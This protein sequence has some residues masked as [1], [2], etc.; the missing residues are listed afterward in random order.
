MATGNEAVTKVVL[1]EYLGTLASALVPGSLDPEVT[2]EFLQNYFGDTYD[3]LFSDQQTAIVGVA[4]FLREYY[5]PSLVSARGGEILLSGGY[6]KLFK[7]TSDEPITP[8]ASDAQANGDVAA[9]VNSSSGYRFAIINERFTIT[10]KDFFQVLAPRDVKDI[11]QAAN[12]LDRIK[13]AGLFDLLFYKPKIQQYA[14]KRY[15]SKEALEKSAIEFADEAGEDL[16]WL[17]ALA[18]VYNTVV[19]D[20]ITTWLMYQYF[21]RLAEFIF[22]AL[23]STADYSNNG[24]GGSENDPL[25]DPIEM[26]KR[27]FKAFGTDEKGDAVFKPAW[28]LINTA[29]R[30]QRALEE[31]PFRANIPPRPPDI[32]HLR[33]GAAN[34]YV[35]PVSINVNSMFKTGSLTGGAIRQKN[36][37]KFNAGYKETTV[38][39]RLFFPNYEEIW[40]ISIKDAANIDLSKDNFSIDFSVDNEDK[41]DKFLSS[42]R[43]LIAAFKYS[44]II[45]IKNQYLNAV[46]GITGVALANMSISTIPNFPF[47]LVVDLELNSFNHKPF[48]PMIKDFNQAVHWGKYRHYM[49]RAAISLDSYIN[50]D[51]LT[52]SKVIE[53]QNEATAALGAPNVTGSIET[54][55]SSASVL[56]T[57]TSEDFSSV[58]NSI[59]EP[60]DS[61]LDT[62]IIRDWENG[63]N[64]SF[65]M[66]ER[67]QSKIFTPDVSTF[68]SQQEKVLNDTGRN[69]WGALLYKF[70]IDINESAGYG[71]T[72][73]QVVV[74]SQGYT[75]SMSLKRKLRT[76]IDLMLAG[77]NEEG[78]NNKVYNYLA[79]S[80]ILNNP[81]VYTVPNAVEYILKQSDV[82]PS[83]DLRI[84]PVGVHA[85]GE[86]DTGQQKENG[87]FIRN[88]LEQLSFGSEGLLE[89]LVSEMVE[90]R[91]KSEKIRDTE[92]NRANIRAEVKEEIAKAFNNTLYERFFM[93]GPIKDYIESQ[94]AKENAYSFREWEVPMVQ[95]DLDPE[96]VIVDG[97]SVNLGNSLV[98]LQLQMQEEPTYQH[99]GGKDSY[100]S[101][102]MTVF[103]E[104]ELIKLRNI[105]EHINGLARLEHAAGVIGFLGIKN[106][107]TSLCG[108]KYVL[109]LKY[110][111]D[112]IPSFPHVYKVQLTLVDFD[113]FQQKREKLSSDQ[114]QKF[115]DEFGTKRNPFLRIKQLWGAFNAYPDLPLELYD[116]NGDVAGCLDPDYYFRSFEMMDRDVVVNQSIQESSQVVV[117]YE[118]ENLTE[119][120]EKTRVREDNAYVE[121][122]V[123]YLKKDDLDGLKVYFQNNKITPTRGYKIINMAI[124]KYSASFNKTLLLDYVDTLDIDDKVYLFTDTKFSVPMGEY[125]V[126]EI[127]SGSAAEMK[128]KLDAV[129]NQTASL[130][131][132][133]VS[134][135]PD[136]LTGSSEGSDSEYSYLHGLVYAIPAADDGWSDQIPA[137][138]QTAGGYNFGYLSRTNGRFYLQNN[139]FTVKKINKEAR[140]RAKAQ[141]ID[142]NATEEQKKQA[143]DLLDMLPERSE[144]ETTDAVTM[145]KVA[146]SQTPDKALKNAHMSEIGTKAFSEYQYAYSGGGAE[147]ESISAGSGDQFSVTKH[148]E[149]MLVDTS[150]RDISGRMVRA[151]PTYMLWLIDEGGFF[152]GTKLFDNFYGLQSIIDFSIVQSEDLLGD[153]LVFR[154]SNMYSKLTRP[155]AS[156]ILRSGSEAYSEYNGENENQ[157]ADNM[158][159]A[160]DRIVD[161]LLNRQ[162]NIRRH[163]ESKYVVDIENIRLKPGVRVH[164]RGGYGSNPNSLQT[165]FNGMITNVEQGEIMTITCQSDAIELSPIINSANKKG[166]SG[167]IDGGMN[168]GMF[169]SEPRDL[170]VKLLSMGTSRFRE[171]LAHSTRGTI[172]SE[173]KFGIRHFGHILYE[174]LNELEAQKNNAIKTAFKNAIEAASDDK[175]NA[176]SLLKAAWK[177]T[178]GSYNGVDIGAGIVSASVGGLVG[179]PMGA[180]AAGTAGFAMRSPIVGH[181]RTLLAN[182]STQRDYEIFKRNIYPG[183]GL[184]VSQFL[185]G[186]LDAGWS[187]AATISGDMHD[188]LQ[189]DRQA[190][191]RRLGDAQWATAVEKESQIAE[192]TARRTSGPLQDSS[193]IIGSAKLISGLGSIAGVGLLAAGMPVVGSAML[194]AGLLGVTNG[195]AAASI[196]ETMGLLSSMDDDMPGFDEVSFRAQT[197]MRSVWDMFQLC[198]RLLPNYIVAVRPFEDRSTVFYGKPH[199]LYTSGV[200]PI[201]TGFLNPDSALKAGVKD[202]GPTLQR[203]DQE[204]VDLLNK[205]NQASSP[206][207]DATAF[208]R[209]FEPFE[210]LKQ[211]TGKIYEGS[212]EFAP[213]GYIR[214]KYTNKLINFYDPRRLFWKEN[215]K[216]VA[217]LPANKGLVNVGFHLPFGEDQ[218]KTELSISEF[219]ANHK[220]IPQLPYRYQFPYFTDRKT[221][222]FDGRHNGYI[223]N[224]SANDLLGIAQGG[225]TDEQRSNKFAGAQEYKTLF[226]A[227]LKALTTSGAGLV[228]LGENLAVQENGFYKLDAFQFSKNLLETISSEAALAMSGKAFMDGGDASSGSFNIIRMPF[229]P[230]SD[231]KISKEEATEPENYKSSSSILLGKYK[232]MAGDTETQSY[233]DFE[234]SADVYSGKAIHKYIRE[235]NIYKEWGMPKTAEDEQFYIAMRW[236]YNPSWFQADDALTK[237]FI[238]VYSNTNLGIN[239]GIDAEDYSS[240]MFGEAQDYKNR[241]VLVYSPTTN[242]AVCCRPAYFLW[243][244]QKD[245]TLREYKMDLGE[246]SY[247]DIENPMI[248]AVVSPDAAYYL[249]ILT[250]TQTINP[251]VGAG[252]DLFGSFGADLLLNIGAGGAGSSAAN[253]PIP[254][255]RQIVEYLESFRE[256]SG[257]SNKFWEK[258]NAGQYFGSYIVPTT[259]S[260]YFTFVEDDFPLGVIPAPIIQPQEYSYSSDSDPGTK[261]KSDKSYIIGFGRSKGKDNQ[262]VTSAVFEGQNDIEFD[263]FKNTS[264]GGTVYREYGYLK[265]ILEDQSLLQNNESITDNLFTPANEAVIDFET[266]KDAAIKSAIGGNVSADFENKFKGYFQ[267]IL[268]GSYDDISPDS[269]YD[270]LA[271]E[272]N[273]FK[274]GDDKDDKGRN[275][276]KDIYD[277]VNDFMIADQARRNYD[278]DFDPA[279]AVIAGNGRT[280]GQAREIWDFFRI[281]FHEDKTV[282][283]IFF[284]AYGI[285]PDD[286]EE[287]PGP[288]LALLTSDSSSDDEI[289]ERYTG[290]YKVG[291]KGFLRNRDA[292]DE[293]EQLLGEEY[294]QRGVQS[295]DSTGG[296]VENLD[297]AKIKE[298]VNYSSEKF[299]DLSETNSE[300]K[301]VRS[302]L[303]QDLD[304]LLMGKYGH[305][306]GLLRFIITPTGNTTGI[307]DE[308][309][310]SEDPTTR[311]IAAFRASLGIDENNASDILEKINSPRKLYLMIVGWF[312]QV[313]WADPYYRAWVVLKPNRRLK[314][315]SSNPLIGGLGDGDLKKSD[316]KWDFSPIFKAWQ[317]F[318]DPNSDYA[319]KPAKFK[320][321]LVANAAEGDSATHWMTAAF[322]DTKDFWD[323][324]IGVYFTAVSDGLSGLLNM[325]KLSMAQMGYGLAEVDNL[326]KQANVL[327]KLLNDSIY[328]SLG[329]PGSLLRAV[330][331]PFTRE[332][333]EPVVEVREPFQR[334]HYLSSFSHILANNIQENINDV[335]TVVTAVSDGKYPVTVAL[336]KGAPPE[337]QTEKTVET[338]LYFD[339]IRGSGFFGVLHPLF[340]P[341]ETIRGVSK[342]SQGAPDE[343]TARRV[344]LAHLKESIKDIYSGELT[345]IGSPDIRPHDLVYLADVYERMYGIFEVEQVVHHFTPDLGFITSITP[346]ALVTVND[347]ARWF[348]TSWLNSWMS[349]QTIRNDTRMYISSANNGRTGIVTGGQV[350]MDS[351]NEALSAQMMGGIQYTHGHSA[352]MKDV[353][354]NF[355]ANALPDTRDKLL[356]QAKNAAGLNGNVS[357]TGALVSTGLATVLGA[358]VGVA[359]T[360]LTGG[361]AA[362]LLAFAG[363]AVA[364][365]AIFGDM[366]W[367][368][369]KYIRDNTLDQHGCYVQYLSKNGQ[370]MDAGLSYNQ[371][372][373][374]GKYHSKAMLPGILGVNS[375]K[376]VRTPEGYSYIRTDDL[377]KNLGWKEK[378]ISDLIRH[379]SYENALVNAQVIKY[380]GVGPEKA[381]LNQFFKVLCYVTRYIDGDTFEVQDILRP[382]SSPF[383]VRFDGINA[384]ELNKI[385]GYITEVGPNYESDYSGSWTDTTSPGGKAAGYVR[386]ALRGKLFVLRVAPSKNLSSELIPINDFDAGAKRNEPNN[387]L[388]DFSSS[389]N[390]FGTNI[391]GTNDRVMGTIFYRTTSNDLDGIVAFVRRTFVEKF[392][393][394][395][396]CKEAIK[397]SIYSDTLANSGT[398]VVHQQFDL[399]YRYL[400]DSSTTNHYSKVSSTEGLTELTQAQINAF[401]ALVEIK[402]LELLYAKASDWPLILWDEF[403]E[404]G[405]PATL[406]WELVVNNLASVYTK[407]LLYNEDSVTLDSNNAYG[408]MVG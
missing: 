30:M 312:R 182:L 289:F 213:V 16:D 401:N 121:T 34:F 206:M 258:D 390:G 70:G 69:F 369:W 51:F 325:F 85:A 8:I 112:T 331:N 167:K 396:L 173:N 223:F 101:M 93:S 405:S 337:R 317:A 27:L 63:N 397:N 283:S 291:S 342:L 377:L 59:N 156:E 58:N 147:P 192:N 137:M 311:S 194:G 208:L 324:N 305:L 329:N 132:E 255:S 298:A 185:G 203:G 10:P 18:K 136:N 394:V 274:D 300:G 201:S 43:G 97:V 168:T 118:S 102:S 114:Q 135:D 81:I 386:D 215:N 392:S 165:L 366:A 110:S 380:S 372:M 103:G 211:Q 183:N 146:D 23:A 166:D 259:R 45:P 100:V 260:C 383:V 163:F 221:G 130:N 74:T 152:A 92:Q 19:K 345:V 86:E 265:E 328:Y 199:W 170:M 171:A 98:K 293:F 120:E 362:P 402:K 139:D 219:D 217:R 68:R 9:A 257:V 126:G 384:G 236:P 280:L 361:A 403:Y 278:E 144:T 33:L 177:N 230:G 352:L 109:P 388:K 57:N 72:L 308:E 91:I 338:G 378:E 216:I 261:W 314:H 315:H 161:V 55:S 141:A 408:R 47:C 292:L 158:G 307:S 61:T 351:L 52:N 54:Q 309:L 207:A 247:I 214:D 29:V 326:N 320:A 187:T 174:P 172:F 197:Y 290:T 210:A 179:G 31:F 269:L 370:P 356:E 244:N 123:E 193:N 284:D 243:G 279:V 341:F 17:A 340:H 209:S 35:P 41:I 48:L 44:P 49:G 233:A 178:A 189:S 198:A 39:I 191:L 205:V 117:S 84:F 319:K 271:S 60:L 5:A 14:R 128:S 13:E 6:N 89:K 251:A 330:D 24:Y 99:V 56:S 253:L 399:L 316:G 157:Q 169:L 254:K 273:T 90:E 381:G 235:N 164:L 155:E 176:A 267:S 256:G 3:L 240:F 248:D 119:D 228:S 268:D 32:F 252:I 181:M 125:K 129:F 115:V 106:I 148:W 175:S 407:G 94:Q 359:A 288:I 154:V 371:G 301:I 153:T 344:A 270:L 239:G 272:V 151:F 113:I 379:I 387:Y 231:D 357:F 353:M 237:K 276:F 21:P 375:R 281:V 66:P 294:I 28:T 111:V 406:N 138:I 200:V 242:T 83:D 355:T 202:T 354:A 190:Y 296:N 42:L 350:S 313:L 20:P 218:T 226:Y 227:E 224:Y 287:L 96:K 67:V 232:I 1:D 264:T 87:R 382:G 77:R 104:S 373:V 322:E 82:V 195:R 346:N 398:Q 295:V 133:L 88:Y 38:S 348:M 73:D 180:V 46:H 241:K 358:G 15:Q 249:G 188:N 71:R 310:S 277:P 250:N 62:N 150:Y 140:R 395:I 134:V 245:A 186:D 393:N 323:K 389:P 11:Q 105:F 282:K 364:G 363:S 131:E 302:G 374:V 365:G 335:A 376:I 347:P 50:R 263:D 40:G 400:D 64:I 2:E 12:I 184:G 196:F 318:V 222:A 76:A 304:T 321:F 360:L 327:N 162:Q 332:Y 143:Q 122:I 212:G 234:Y 159:D 220:Q 368:G 391:K 404:D 36:T 145:I 37:P 53:M 229:P 108:I 95:V 299:L 124:S 80:Y 266:E 303:F 127:T 107:I 333:G 142:P 225:E 116:K 238:D 385:S 339:N 160:L 26:A 65:F 7:E 285:D 149:K 75:T 78:I 349:L 336:D 306:T 262:Q 343:L 286:E 204:L 79:T 297:S 275:A 367:T 246:V 22:T 4:D 334:I 25:N